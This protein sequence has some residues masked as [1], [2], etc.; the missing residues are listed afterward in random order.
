M[1]LAPA[2]NQIYYFVG[3]FFSLAR[4]V[5]SSQKVTH[6]KKFWRS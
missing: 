6:V 1:P 4:A 3:V 2:F 5:Q